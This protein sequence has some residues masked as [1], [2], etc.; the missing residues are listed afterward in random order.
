MI[1]QGPV[2]R[3]RVGRVCLVALTGWLV[4]LPH[5]GKVWA[6][7]PL[8]LAEG[9]I[10][11]G[12]TRSGTSQVEKLQR[13]LELLDEHD[14]GT[15]AP[16]PLPPSPPQPGQARH[17]LRPADAIAPEAAAGFLPLPQDAA[18]RLPAEFERQKSLLL[19]CRE[20]LT[21]VPDLFAEI[22]RETSGRVAI[23]ALVSDIDEYRQARDILVRRRVRGNHVRFVTCTHDTM[24]SRDYGP[25]IVRHRDGS[26]A[27]IDAEYDFNR[28]SDDLVPAL[29]ARHLELPLVQVAMRI[30]GGNLLS[31]GQGLCIATEELLNVNA[32]RG[33]TED[34][35][36]EV[37]RSCF[38]TTQLVLLEP[39]VGEMTGHV[40]MFATFT[41]PDTVVV[42]SIA[43]ATD[44]VNA[45]ILDRNAARLAA[46]RTARGPLNV[47]RI[48]MAPHG[49]GV[50]RTYTNVIYANGLLLVPIYPG[51]DDAGQRQ[52]MQTYARLLP[53]WRIVGLDVRALCEL[54]GALHCISMNLGPA[55]P[56][57]T[58]RLNRPRRRVP[59][60]AGQRRPNE[61]ELPPFSALER[62]APDNNGL[63]RRAV[64]AAVPR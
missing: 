57:R 13:L 1:E 40:D 27:V 53:G 56:P 16:L 12:E 33:M 17:R 9:T 10:D 44:P 39:L 24:W 41:A 42:G 37:L 6:E 14:S 54:G 11:R 23:V 49:D 8:E 50:W 28:G 52:A 32:E 22:V 30:E 3:H 43:K 55:Q 15:Q 48:P 59:Q 51:L 61:T 31:N 63:S 29:L 45:A 34:A 60:Q 38:G 26:A 47:V 19:S 62:I 5:A 46:V 4:L 58:H 36:A 7:P 2:A 21:E 64:W 35:A 20:L 18:F 25:F